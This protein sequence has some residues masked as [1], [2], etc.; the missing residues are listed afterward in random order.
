MRPIEITPLAQGGPAEQSEAQ[1]L[2]GEFSALLR[3]IGPSAASCPPG[4]FVSS[5]ISNAN[6]A[7]P[8]LGLFLETYQAR[9]LLPVELP[10]IA[11]ACDHAAHGRVRE[12]L[13]LD[14]RLAEEPLLQR[15]ADGS[16]QAGRAQLERLRP[17]RDDRT[18]RR[19]LA[20]VDA[21]EAQGWH[22]LVFGIMLAI[23]S[24]PLRQGLLHFG[25]ETMAGLALAASAAPD[26]SAQVGDQMLE[27]LF[28]Q[29]P[30]A[31]DDLIARQDIR[32]AVA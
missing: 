17:L 12:L 19:Y 16:R 29:M 15:F 30:A 26:S 2:L 31:I 32:L 1:A 22:T 8:S 4:F 10:A 5:Q 27:A 9:L 25:R 11:E 20:A 6:A 24:W 21:G 14:R 7:P 3:R 23:Y 28:A 18:L 13:A